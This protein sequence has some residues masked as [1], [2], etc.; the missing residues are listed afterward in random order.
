[1][2]PELEGKVGKTL[3]LEI[4]SPLIMTLLAHE[5]RPTI[6]VCI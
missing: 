2:K 1:M 3:H 4:K 6:E 5:L